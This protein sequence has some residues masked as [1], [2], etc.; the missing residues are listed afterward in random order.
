MGRHKGDTNAPFAERLFRKRV[1][2]ENDCWEWT[3]AKTHNGYGLV[4]RNG[5]VELAHRAAYAEFIGDIPEDRIVMH[6]CDNRRCF[7]PDHLMLGSVAANQDDMARKGRSNR[8]LPKGVIM[9]I[10]ERA[11][12]VRDKIRENPNWP[13]HLGND[14]YR[15]IADDFGVDL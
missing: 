2:R 4:Q 5:K 15:R 7:N 11:L 6:K 8:V 13:R 12:I 14:S 9:Q 10:R 1:I 3:G